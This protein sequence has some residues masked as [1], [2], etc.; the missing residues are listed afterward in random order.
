MVKMLRLGDHASLHRTVTDADIL[1]F[2]EVVGDHNP[3][4]VDDEYAKTTRFHGRIAHGAFAVGLVSSVLGNLLPGPGSVYLS[5]TARFLKPVRPGD[6][7]T[8][9]VIVTDI[10]VGKPIVTLCTQCMNQLGELVLDGEA[11]V[12]FDDVKEAKE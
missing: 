7:V 6:T 9:S 3:L 5:Q 4:H 1:S 11:V 8:V 10:K 12:L 2:A